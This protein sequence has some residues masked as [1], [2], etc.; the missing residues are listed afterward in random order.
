MPN[1]LLPSRPFADTW[2]SVPSGFY[3]AEGII[4]NFN[5]IEEYRNADKA[6]MLHQSAKTVNKH[7]VFDC[8]VCRLI[9]SSR[10]GMRSM[11]GQYIR[12]HH[13]WRPF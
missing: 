6:A 3:R 2:S 8:C 7:E 5:T 4:K 12:V 9:I 13:C 10:F 1:Q 11:M